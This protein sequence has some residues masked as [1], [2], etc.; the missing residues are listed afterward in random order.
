MIFA[1][2]ITKKNSIL[3]FRAKIV[4]FFSFIFQIIPNSQMYVI[5]HPVNEPDQWEAKLFITP[6]QGITLTGLALVGTCGLIMLIIVFLH[7]RERKADL[8]E[9]L[10]EAH[11]FHFDAM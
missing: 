4:N 11:R 6:S 1:R 8:R 5:P 10:Q 3:N 2:K 7:W 9:K